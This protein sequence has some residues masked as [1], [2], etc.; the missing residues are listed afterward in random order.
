MKSCIGCKFANWDKTKAGKLHPSGD[1]RCTY[2]YVPRPIPACMYWLSSPKP[3]GGRIS[4][5]E[6]MKDHCVYY[7]K[8]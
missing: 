6:E 3:D 7:A 5:R 2:K 8:E 4:R 1:G